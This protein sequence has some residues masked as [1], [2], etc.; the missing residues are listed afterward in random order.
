MFVLP[1]NRIAILFPR[2]VFGSLET[3]FPKRFQ[4]EREAEPRDLPVWA[5]PTALNQIF[6][7]ISRA[8]FC[9]AS[10]LEE[11]EPCDVRLA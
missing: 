4:A 5:K 11:P 1:S 10:F 8:A 9:L 3:F 7:S 6:P 2:K